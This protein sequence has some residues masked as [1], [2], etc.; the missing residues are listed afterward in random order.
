M[1]SKTNFMYVFLQHFLKCF[2]GNELQLGAFFRRFN[3]VGPGFQLPT[4]VVPV[5]GGV[6]LLDMAVIHSLD[7]FCML[8]VMAVLL[9][10]DGF[11]M[12]LIMVVLHLIEGFCMLLVTAV[13]LVLDGFCMPLFLA[14][15]QLI[16][17]FWPILCE[18]VVY[19][20]MDHSTLPLFNFS[21]FTPWNLFG[22]DNWYR[23]VI[24][25]FAL[26]AWMLLNGIGIGVLSYLMVENLKN[27]VPA[28]VPA[29]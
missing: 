10:L 8:L 27:Q 7:G 5:A 23:V 1:T 14:V 4:P 12:L 25:L 6:L 16:D 22:G 9:V 19:R 13:L 3:I 21:E 18:S 2:Y 20:T 29:N 15:L 17:G 26:G 11:C 24:L 28:L